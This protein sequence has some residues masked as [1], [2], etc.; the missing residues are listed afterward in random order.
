MT[1]SAGV[2]RALAVVAHPDDESFGLGGL[3]DELV[4]RGAEVSV[5]CFTHGEAS[6]LHGCD[7]GLAAVRAAE[8]DAAAAILAVSHTRLLD[9]PDGAL[10]RIPV[11]EL[12]ARVRELAGELHP[13]H[14]MAFDEGGITG[15]P[16]HVQATRAA[17]AAASELNL[18]VFGWALPQAVASALN[19]EYGTSFIGRPDHQIDWELTVD[20][21]RQWRAIAAHRS[22]STGN[23]VLLRRLEL[24]GNREHV[25]ILRVRNQ[26]RG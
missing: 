14:L 15:H 12:A 22:Q 5:L 2:R 23:P 7:G 21:G 1:W 20:R 19:T 25:R 8:L 9:Y 16:D 17:L 13:T 4:R 6:T 3:L 10:S 11:P 26:A 24:L 18:P